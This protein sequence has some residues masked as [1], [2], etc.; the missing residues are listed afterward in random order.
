MT[1]MSLGCRVGRRLSPRRRSLSG[2]PLRP[3]HRDTCTRCLASCFSEQ[4]TRGHLR[5]GRAGIGLWVVLVASLSLSGDAAFTSVAG[6][7]FIGSYGSFEDF[8]N[9]IALVKD[10][11]GNVPLLFHPRQVSA[12]NKELA[13][14]MLGPDGSTK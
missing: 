6:A 11:A 12:S 14:F 4:A 3:Q 9:Q 5:S 10:P 2:P 13:Y 8:P 7:T 1:H